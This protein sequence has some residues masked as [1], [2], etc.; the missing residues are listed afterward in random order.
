VP[1]ITSVTAFISW[2]LDDVMITESGTPFLSVKLCLFVPVLRLSTGLFPVIARPK[3]DFTDKLSSDCHHVDM[4]PFLLSYSF[5]NL[6]HIFLKTSLSESTLE[7]AYGMLS[8]SHTLKVAFS[9]GI[10]F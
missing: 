5:N 8:Q 9:I 10:V 7:I 1:S 2:V 4:M 3:G 6:V